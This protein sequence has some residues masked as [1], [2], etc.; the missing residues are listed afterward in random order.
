MIARLV[1]NNI[2]KSNHVTRGR[3]HCRP[4]GLGNV[5]RLLCAAEWS[6]R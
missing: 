1:T 5:L 3:L 6:R 2:I 4:T